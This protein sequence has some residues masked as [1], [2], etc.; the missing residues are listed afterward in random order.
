ML[1][2]KTCLDVTSGLRRVFLDAAGVIDP[3]TRHSLE[4]AHGEQPL[5]A[6]RCQESR[7]DRLHQAYLS[8]LGNA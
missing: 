3:L 4:S 1:A 8:T 6:F 7:M 2:M 5:S